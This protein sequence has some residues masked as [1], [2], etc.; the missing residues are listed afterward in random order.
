M[1]SQHSSWLSHLLLP[2][3]RNRQFWQSVIDFN[4]YAAI[5]LRFLYFQLIP[6][7]VLITITLSLS[8]FHLVHHLIYFSTVGSIIIGDD[9]EYL[10][11]TRHPFFILWRKIRSGVKG[12]EIWS[13]EDGHGPS[14]RTRHY[15]NSIHINFVEI[16]TFLAVDLDI[17]EA[18]IHDLSDS[19][20][21]K[22]LL[23]HD[24]APVARGITDAEENGLILS[25]GP[26][27]GLLSPGM[28]IHR[29]MRV[30]QEV[31]AC[32]MNQTIYVLLLHFLSS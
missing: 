7:Q 6:K 1:R 17:D 23:F 13:Q 14:P 19:L 12:N 11:E 28:P 31:G 16:W 10:R 9:T 2:E 24:M 25:F 4:L 27:E 32:L 20:I 8:I 21:L 5:R 29:V 22:G 26:A 30:L 15:L 18:I 3:V